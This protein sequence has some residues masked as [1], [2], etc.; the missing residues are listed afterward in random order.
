MAL[1]TKGKKTS[2]KED[3]LIY[4]KRKEDTISGKQRWKTLSGKE[5]LTQFKDYY[6]PAIVVV[7]FA[8]GIVGYLFYHDFITRK[9]IIYQ[10]AIINDV[11]PEDTLRTFST[12]YL[13]FTGHDNEKEA[14][15]F[16]LYYNNPE[17]A[18]KVH[19]SP[20]NDTQQI[21]AFIFANELDSMI[22]DSETLQVYHKSKLLMDL[23]LYLTEEEQKK[24][25]PFLYYPENKAQNPD[26]KPF[27]IKLNKSSKYLS[28]FVQSKPYTSDP[29]IS[30]LINSKNKD[31]THKLITYLF[32]DIFTNP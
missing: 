3:A 23:S 12:D 21:S 7:V 22:A 4:E 18:S 26:K 30:V 27:G 17:L 32:P 9:D 29:I 5:R 13:S 19:A 1:N 31:L 8:A 16:H 20:S 24:L 6:L 11:I 2:L 15:S 10:C 14:A 28:L 25:E